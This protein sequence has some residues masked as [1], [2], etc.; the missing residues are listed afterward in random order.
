M[1]IQ[2]PKVVY[3]EPEKQY[4]VGLDLMYYNKYLTP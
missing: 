1:I 2:R 4:H 3:S